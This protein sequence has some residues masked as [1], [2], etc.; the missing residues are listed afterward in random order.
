MKSVYSPFLMKPS[1]TIQS[2]LFS[3]LLLL[4]LAPAASAQRPT[5]T[6]GKAANATAVVYDSVLYNGLRW[7]SIGP[8]RGGRAGTVTGVLGPRS[9]GPPVPAERTTPA[10]RANTSWSR[11][12]HGRAGQRAQNALPQIGGRRRRKGV[13]NRQVLVCQIPNHARRFRIA[14]GHCTPRCCARRPPGRDSSGSRSWIAA[15]SPL[16]WRRN[17]APRSFLGKSGAA[18]GTS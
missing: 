5:K 9:T 8:Y 15:T 10:C 16:R 11:S 7:R 2:C 4:L 17:S 1:S 13:G 3:V 14:E 12:S 6:R 18:R